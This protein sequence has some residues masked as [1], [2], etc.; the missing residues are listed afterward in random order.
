MSNLPVDRSKDYMHQ[1]WGT[2]KLIT[3]YEVFTEK[4]KVIQEIMHDDIEKNKFSLSEKSHEFIRN[5]NDYDDWDY[6][7]EPIYGRPWS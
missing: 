5:D 7:T 6:G 4:K 2:T 3:D 1:M